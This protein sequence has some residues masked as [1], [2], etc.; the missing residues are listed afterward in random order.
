MYAS[1]V[2][3]PGFHSGKG[4]VDPVF[5]ECQSPARPPTPCAEFYV[6][7]NELGVQWVLHSV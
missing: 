2:I 3:D 5:R 7:T 4:G 6:R 1:V